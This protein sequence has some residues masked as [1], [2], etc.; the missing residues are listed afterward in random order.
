L[1][2][3]AHSF[4]GLTTLTNASGGVVSL[5]GGTIGDV[6]TNNSGTVVATGT[7]TI[8]G[9]FNNL[10]GGVVDLT[11][12]STPTTNQLNTGAFH[13]QAGS[14]VNVTFDFSTV[15][16]QAGLLTANGT[17]GTTTVNFANVTAGTPVILGN[18]VTV[19]KDK[20]GSGTLSPT[21]VTEAFGLVNVSVQSDGH[22][23]AD[24]VRTL[25]VGAAAAPGASVMAALSS[26]DTSFHQSTAPFVVSP[27]SQDA[28][29]WTGGVWTRATAGQTT[30]KSTAFESFGGTSAALRVKTN[31]D[32]YEVGVDTGILNFGNT[33]WNG[34]FGVMAGAVTATANELLSGS[35][36]SVKFDIPFAGV[37]GVMTRGPFFMDLEGRHDWVDTRV[38]NVTANLNDARLKGH[39]DS[40]SGSA[41]YHFDLVDHWFIEPTAGFG[42]SQTQFDPLATN[43]NQTGQGIAAGTV[44]FDSLSSFLVHGGARIGTSFVVS[45][46]LA[47]Q[48]FGTLSAWRELA[49]QSNATFANSGVSD[50][51]TLS[52]V[53]TFYQGGVGLS[54]QVLN[55][56]FVGFARGDIRWGDNLNGMSLVGGLRYTFGP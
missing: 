54:A 24:L 20:T 49:G 39:A 48:P 38:T 47:L 8:N 52:R 31:F 40:L 56:G 1:T 28:D 51:L 29:Q 11:K 22:G 36:T 10:P 9:A 23:G 41:G 53:G 17:S 26:I 12:G 4:T 34:H 21:G 46:T 5:S 14:A 43:L 7:S 32:A 55:T 42:W 44:T 37:Y 15:N 45:D 3:G 16:G 27:P 30:T 13:G 6:A 18:A 33:G 50:P 35:G 19:I 25:N 2:V